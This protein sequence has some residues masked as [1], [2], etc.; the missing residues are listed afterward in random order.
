MIN[1]QKVNEE[2]VFIDMTEYGL[3]MMVSINFEYLNFMIIKFEKSYEK[4]KYFGN[5]TLEEKYIRMFEGLKEND[6]YFGEDIDRKKL[7]KR[8]WDKFVDDCLVYVMLAC[9]LKIKPIQ[10]VHPKQILKILNSKIK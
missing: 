10:L 5:Q 7:E 9:F 4:E 6:E 8:R 3:N 1:I 2:N